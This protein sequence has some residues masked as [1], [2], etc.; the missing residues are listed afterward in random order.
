MDEAGTGIGRYVI[1]SG[2]NGGGTG[3]EGMS[4][5]GSCGGRA[6]EASERG[7]GGGRLV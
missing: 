7:S 2:K 5:G 6:L 4:V 3:V 1:A